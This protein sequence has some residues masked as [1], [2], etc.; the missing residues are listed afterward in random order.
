MVLRLVLDLQPNYPD[1]AG[2][3]TWDIHHFIFFQWGTK[4]EGLY[5]NGIPASSAQLKIANT[6]GVLA[7]DG[8]LVLGD[9]SAGIYLDELVLQNTTKSSREI[10]DN[11]LS[12]LTGSIGA[13][14]E[15]VQ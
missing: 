7:T 3:G 4:D 14:F 5:V 6:P 13:I 12:Y 1:T 2:K 11:F 10:L 9:K 8:Q 15:D